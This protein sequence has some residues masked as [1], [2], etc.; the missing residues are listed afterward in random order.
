MFEKSRIQVNSN[1]SEQQGPNLLQMAF[2]LSE[3]GKDVLAGAIKS[4]VILATEDVVTER[5]SMCLSCDKLKKDGIISRCMACGCGMNIKTR[6][7]K[8]K[9]PLSKWTR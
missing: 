9:C 8:S 1:M 7:E 4:G 6:L 2:S 5:Q 3:T